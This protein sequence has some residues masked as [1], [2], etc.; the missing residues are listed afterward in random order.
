MLP[1]QVSIEPCGCTRVADFSE[2]NAVILVPV[3]SALLLNW[4]FFLS[5]CFL[6]QIIRVKVVDSM[7][8]QGE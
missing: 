3:M 7:W 5:R 4:N 2:V 8:H 1:M 6:N